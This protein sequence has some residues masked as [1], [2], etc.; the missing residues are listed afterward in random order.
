ME[1]IIQMYLRNDYATIAEY[2]AEAGSVAEK[3]HF[4]VIA[5]F[6]VNFSD[7]AARRLRNIAASGARCGVYTLAQCDQRQPL[8]QDFVPDE[9]R[10]NA[11]ALVPGAQGFGPA[12][13][14]LAGLRL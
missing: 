2:N 12:G 9:L 13:S 3:Y 7:T 14:S 6:P 5:S 4:L 11:A 1:K 10:K 8:P